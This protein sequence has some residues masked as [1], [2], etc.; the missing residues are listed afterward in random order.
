MLLMTFKD[1]INLIKQD[2]AYIFSIKKGKLIERGNSCYQVNKFFS[3]IFYLYY[4]SGLAFLV[5]FFIFLLQPHYFNH[6]IMRGMET[7]MIYFVLETIA[8]FLL[9]VKKI[10]CRDKHSLA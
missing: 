10:V 7:L 3:W 9:P 1:K 4:Y 6:I 8:F 2:W 5:I